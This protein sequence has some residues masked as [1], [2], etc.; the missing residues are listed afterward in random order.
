MGLHPIER[1]HAVSG[2]RRAVAHTGRGAGDRR[3]LRH[4]PQGCGRVLGLSPMR[5]IGRISYSW[6]LWHWPVLV[7][8]PVLL[9]HPL[10][11][12][13]RLAAALLSA[14][15]A[16]FTLRF[17]ENPLRF[18]ARVR[19]SA[20]RS[21][22]LGGAATA[23]AVCVGVGLLLVVPTPVGRG[24][25][26]TP[27]TISAASL[28]TGSDATAYDAAVQHMFA[29]FQAA[30]TAAADLKAVPSNLQPSI[31]AAAGEQKAFCS[32]VASAF[33]PRWAAGVRHGRYHVA[34][35]GG[36]GRRLAC[37]DV[38]S[39]VS[40]DRWATALA[41]G[42]PGESGLPIARRAHRQPL[43]PPD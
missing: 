26:A 12:A 1:G 30:V 24:A 35:D 3:G 15:L 21:L 20:W 33:F 2:H 11:L 16:V 36:P 41:A 38:E 18:A 5:A 42:D 43:L 34:D 7:L 10:G 29:Q 40:A 39:G 9:G 27:L 6:Y 17:I 4:A 14:G 28:P 13:A 8:A 19:S 37:R 23:V 31:A 32:T 25:P 22:A